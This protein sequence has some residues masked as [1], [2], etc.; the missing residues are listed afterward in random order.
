MP[1][2][3]RNFK[4]APEGHTTITLP[5][6][7]EVT[8]VIAEKARKAGALEKAEVNPS[9]KPTNTKPAAPTETK[10]AKPAVKA[11]GGTNESAS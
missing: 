1:K 2:L 10:P 7:T 9:P 4:V 5:K 3:S 11:Q 8:G 6:G